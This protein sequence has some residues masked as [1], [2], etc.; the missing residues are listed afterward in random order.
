MIPEWFIAIIEAIIPG[1]VVG[2]VLAVWNRKQNKKSA[3]SDKKA[4]NAERKDSLEIALLVATAELSYATTM[5]I[6][7]GN[8]NGEVEI[9]VKRYNKAMEQFREFERQQLYFID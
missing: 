2:V 3:V 7:R 5:A 6:K 8:P 1:L 9:A 4:A